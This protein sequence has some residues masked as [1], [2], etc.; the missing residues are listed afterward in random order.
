MNNGPRLEREEDNWMRNGDFYRATRMLRVYQ[1]GMTLSLF[2]SLPPFFP[3][4]FSFSVDPRSASD[5]IPIGGRAFA[6][7][8]SR[9]LCNIGQRVSF[10]SLSRSRYVG[11]LRTFAV[12]ASNVRV[13]SSIYPQKR[14][15]MCFFWERERECMS[16]F[17]TLTRRD[18]WIS[19]F[20]TQYRKLVTRSF[21]FNP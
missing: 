15:K 14:V 16:A 6:I 20:E 12:D 2:F 10:A 21:L 3:F 18:W 1:T 13:E 19:F 7:R 4:P 9:D 5:R 17:P 11:R 8:V